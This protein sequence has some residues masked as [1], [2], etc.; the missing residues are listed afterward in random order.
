MENVEKR[1]GDIVISVDYRI[2][3]MGVITWLGKYHKGMPDLYSKEGN[4]E[5]IEEITKEFKPYAKDEIIKEFD[6]IVKAFDLYS[7]DSFKL[8]LQ[9]DSDLN[10]TNL[11]KNERILTF[12]SKLKDFSEKVGFDNFFESHKD[13]YESYVENFSNILRTYDISKFMF[14]YFGYKINKKIN[15]I[16]MPFAYGESFTHVNDFEIN[17][18]IPVEEKEFTY[19]NGNE[20]FIL[21]KIVYEVTKELINA[22][23]KTKQIVLDPNMFDDIK[24]VL[25]K[26][27]L[28]TNEEILNEH[29]IKSIENRFIS[30]VLNN[31]GF[32]DGR[33]VFNI[34]SGFVYIDYIIDLL[35]HYEKTKELY[36]SFEEYYSLIVERLK[37]NI[38]NEKI[39][40]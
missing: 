29:I 2:E 32:A 6:E 14:E 35:I 21:E 31:E 20:Y 36:N 19:E 16:L 23:S 1:V 33:K 22:I 5:Y 18:L 7:E 9:L 39:D 28:E 11:I 15:V 34:T 13:E 27:N 8:F 12:S 38:R 40:E 10:P 30:I 3:L 26:Y 4:K 37:E 24:A 25:S 17:I